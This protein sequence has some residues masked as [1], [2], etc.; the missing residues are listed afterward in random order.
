MI[1]WDA[2]VLA[3]LHSVFGEGQGSQ[4]TDVQYR[5]GD[6]VPVPGVT[7]VWTEAGTITDGQAD[8]AINQL[9]PTLGVRLSQFPADYDPRNARGDTFVVR[10]IKYRVRMGRP[11]S[12]GGATLEATRA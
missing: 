6:S 11:D 2:T 1:D 4:L 3:P 8:P 12:L 5:R 7:G 9:A 10:G